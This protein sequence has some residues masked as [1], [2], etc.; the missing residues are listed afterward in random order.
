MKSLDIIKFVLLLF[1]LSSCRREDYVIETGESKIVVEG[2]IEDGEEAKVLLTRS[3][4]ISEV[5]DSSNFLKY[6]IRSATVIVSDGVEID[7]LRLTSASKYLPPFLY[8]GNKIKGKV[9]ENYTLTIKYLSQTLTAQTTIP[10]PVPIINVQYIRQN[11][12]DTIGNLSIEFTDPSDQENYYQI[13]TLLE[14]KDEIFIPSVYGNL[15][16]KNFISPNVNAK[17]TRGITVFPH[18]NF[19][20]YFNDGDSIQVRLRTMTEEG[21]AFWNSWQNELINSQ[22]VIFPAN[23]SLNGN[24]NGG[25]GIWCGYGQNTMRIIAR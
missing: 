7:T 8:V 18:T 19:K 22:N 4:P 10:P 2:W 14:G 16:D 23:R 25:I 21:F 6:A 3:V 5:L 13:A 20:A 17:I 24:I 15:S 11:P 1:A 12:T 9:G